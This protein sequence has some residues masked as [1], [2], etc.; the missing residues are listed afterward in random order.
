MW[1]VRVAELF[2]TLWISNLKCL[3]NHI[4]TSLLT[5]HPSERPPQIISI[6][7]LP[8]HSRGQPTTAAVIKKT[9]DALT[10]L[11]ADFHFSRATRQRQS[12]STRLIVPGPLS[13][14]GQE[15]SVFRFNSNTAARRGGRKHSRRST[16]HYGPGSRNAQITTPFVLSSVINRLAGSP[17]ARLGAFS[18]H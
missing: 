14:G 9:A 11:T 15:R 3:S 16:D 4:F 2:L 10:K 6:S 5:F 13:Y 7:T 8:R 1:W 17:P 12:P 18:A